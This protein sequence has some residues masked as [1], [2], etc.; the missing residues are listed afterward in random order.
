MKKLKRHSLPLLIMIPLL[1]LVLA[2][3]AYMM[4]YDQSIF[5]LQHRVSDALYSAIRVYGV[6][7][8]YAAECS[9]VAQNG[10][11]IQWLLEIAR[12]GAMIVMATAVIKLLGHTFQHLWVSLAVKS[13]RSV[14]LY[15]DAAMVA[16]MKEELG[17]RAITFECPEQFNA[18]NHVLAFHDSAQLYRFINEHYSELMSRK[19]ARLFLY[20][21]RLIHPAQ[22]N[23]RVFIN[24]MTETCAR[25][26]WKKHWLRPEE[27]RI[28]L[29]SCGEYGGELLSQALRV[30]VFLTEGLCEY[31]VYGNSEQ[32]QALHPQLHQ[33]VSVN[34]QEA[35]KDCV[36]FHQ[37]PWYLNV[38]D[39]K[40]ADRIIICGDSESENIDDLDSLLLQGVHIPIYV[41]VSSEKTL[42]TFGEFD[43]AQTVTPFG[44][45]Q[46]L[47]AVDQVTNTTSLSK[48]RLIHAC[49]YSDNL[50]THR[51]A[52][53][54]QTPVACLACTYFQENWNSHTTD[55]MRASSI[56]Q[57]DHIP[58]KIR[59]LLGI[60]TAD[61]SA[62][63]GEAYEAYQKLSEEQKLSY[64]ELEHRRWMRFMY[65][66]GWQYA[67]VRNDAELRHNL[68]IPFFD[69]PIVDI[70]KRKD[71]AAYFIMKD[72]SAYEHFKKTML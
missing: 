70:K 39:I 35:Q 10:K 52:C 6:S 43:N 11:L 49:Y 58:V 20:A 55:Y 23:P 68:L 22:L 72:V 15:G 30:N 8:D 38:E 7:V 41:R 3:I 62:H 50:C 1:P 17:K 32:Y 67:P 48:G 40:K 45:D 31:H 16:A 61:T 54:K 57:A 64:M 56:A 28:A 42:L 19:G 36:F 65:L 29:I 53:T 26:Y 60:P 71:E 25:T 13:K 59:L 9:K 51:K 46:E 4:L 14:A 2:F 21:D 33:F 44:T 5:G 66:R 69:A 12:W 27:H 18:A 63:A 24:N 34:A 47:Y 37:Q